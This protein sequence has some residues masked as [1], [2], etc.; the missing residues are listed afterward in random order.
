MLLAS[1][2]DARGCIGM[3]WFERLVLC[4]D[5]QLNDVK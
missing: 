1:Q 4:R 5:G 3:M 2:N